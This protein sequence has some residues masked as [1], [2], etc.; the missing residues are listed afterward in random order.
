MNV[1]AI[2]FCITFLILVLSSFR[3]REFV[4]VKSVIGATAK[5]SLSPSKSVTSPSNVSFEI[6]KGLCQ[7]RGL[8]GAFQKSLPRLRNSGSNLNREMKRKNLD[9]SKKFGFLAEE[10]SV[11]LLKVGRY[12]LFQLFVVCESLGPQPSF[13]L[14]GKGD[15]RTGPC[16]VNKA[17]GQTLPI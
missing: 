6:G 11:Q 8:R 4:F 9:S 5:N 17:D 7:V 13:E 15:N 2:R 3:E 12:A 16:L 1:S 14:G 10:L